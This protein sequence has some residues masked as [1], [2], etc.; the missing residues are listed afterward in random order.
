MQTFKTPS[1]SKTLR[2][3]LPIYSVQ[4]VQCQAH[5]LGYRHQRRSSPRF[6]VIYRRKHF[7][8][9]GTRPFPPIIFPQS[10]SRVPPSEIKKFK[11]VLGIARRVTQI[12]SRRRHQKQDGGWETNWAGWKKRRK[13]KGVV[14]GE[15]N[16][17]EIRGT[18]ISRLRRGNFC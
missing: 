18:K 1:T 8:I 11:I 5:P 16:N 2:S 6:R 12:L 13:R 17:S 10:R 15:K 9:N 4:S 7:L 14:E 3:K